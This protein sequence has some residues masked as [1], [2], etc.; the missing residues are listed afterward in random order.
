MPIVRCRKLALVLIVVI[1]GAALEEED[2]KEGGETLENVTRS[3]QRNQ[4]ATI[5]RVRLVLVCHENC[6]ET[7]LVIK[8]HN[9]L[10]VGPPSVL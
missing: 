4:R 7:Q 8:V 5:G 10:Q 3:T 6:L 1:T 2:E 9:L